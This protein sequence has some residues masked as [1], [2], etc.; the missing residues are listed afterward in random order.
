VFH[1][2]AGLAL[3]IAGAAFGTAG[4]GAGLLWLPV[5][6]LPLVLLSLGVGW[7]LA[8]VGVFLRDIGQV[9]AFVATALL[10]ASAVMYPPAKIPAGFEWLR[11]N[12]LLQIV[13]LARRTVLWH[14]PMAWERLAYV[15]AV[16]ALAFAVGAV[17]FSLLRKSFAEVV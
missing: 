1:L 5:L 11:F 17:L 14:E 13:D 6:I 10:F 12:P 16:G 8:A 7:A 9:T 4:I 2:L 3:I 15:Y